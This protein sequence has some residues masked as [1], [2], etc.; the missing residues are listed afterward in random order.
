MVELDAAEFSLE[1]LVDDVLVAGHPPTYTDDQ[2]RAKCEA[3]FQHVYD[4]Y[5]DASRNIYSAA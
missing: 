1:Y 5:S 2:F 3:I 4:S